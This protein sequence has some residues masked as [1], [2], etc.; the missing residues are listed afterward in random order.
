MSAAAAI[1]LN[2][3]LH[4]VVVGSTFV[5]NS[6][7]NGGAIG[8]LNSDLDVYNSTFQGNAALGF[9]ANGDDQS[10][11]STK[12]TNGQYQ[13]GSGGNGGAISIDGGLDNSHTFC[14][15]TFKSN[16]GGKGA[17]GGAFFRTPDGDTQAMT[18][19]RCDFDG[20]TGATAGV[21]Y[22]QNS[23]FTVT[24]STFSNNSAG[25]FGVMQINGGTMDFTNDTFTGNHATTGVGGTLA[26]FGATGKLLNCTFADN[27]CDSTVPSVGF[28][29][30]IFGGPSLT[31]Q[32]TLF[33]A[34]TAREAPCS[35]RWAPSPATATCSGRRTTTPCARRR[36]S[37]VPTRRSGHSVITADR[38]PP[39]CRRRAA[40]HRSA[41]P[42]ARPPTPA[43]SRA[44]R[45]RAPP[46]PSRDR[47]ERRRSRRRG[48]SGDG[49]HRSAAAARALAA[50]DGSV[51]A[52]ASRSTSAPDGGVGDR[53]ARS[54]PGGGLR[55]RRR[56][57]RFRWQ[58]TPVLVSW[59]LR[60]EV[61]PW[62]F[63]VADPL[64]RHSGSTELFVAPEYF[65]HGDAADRW[66]VRPGVRTYL[67]LYQ[68]G[69]YASMSLGAS[70]F[71]A[72]AHGGRDSAGFELGAYALYGVF[73][74]VVTYDPWDGPTRVMATL[75]VRFF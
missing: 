5:N 8:S 44:W 53:A 75:N 54:Q 1:Y 23:T 6:G 49:A 60:R 34:N 46:A 41:A 36:S 27:A 25:G 68:R 35:A 47:T 14:G 39:W 74:A 15:S 58:V 43:G 4:A 55:Q 50:G 29:S 63:F 69:E 28:A 33:D 65:F 52:A 56:V 67:P 48:P 38:C 45:L 12:A 66:S 64:A 62:R 70:Y 59:G 13:T 30:V 31:I 42:G 26:I 20:N 2:G 10:M 40:R 21:V 11:C 32:N 16:T 7:A 73:G 18:V 61:S 19:D 71:H 3:A 24:S 9:G 57:R 37:K 72:T 17:F 22:M 51:A